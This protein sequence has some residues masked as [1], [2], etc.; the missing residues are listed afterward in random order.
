MTILDDIQ[1]VRT[2]AVNTLIEQS[3]EEATN[4]KYGIKTSICNKS[5]NTICL[6]ILMYGLD[7]FESNADYNFLTEAQVLSII[8]K[9]QELTS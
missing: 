6:Y 2:K 9:L 1:L 7:S 8:T 4:I 3:I 5:I